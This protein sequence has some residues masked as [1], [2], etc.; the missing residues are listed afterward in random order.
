MLVSLNARPV[1]SGVRPLREKSTM[2]KKAPWQ[3]RPEAKVIGKIFSAFPE[4]TPPDDK[5]IV[6]AEP[7]HLT[8][9]D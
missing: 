7:A 5:N 8:V 4:T 3:N 9:C 6:A 2:I 1:N